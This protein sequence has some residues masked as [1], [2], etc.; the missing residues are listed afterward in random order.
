MNSFNKYL[1]SISYVPGIVI[2]P[3]DV[4]VNTNNKKD[5]NPFF[6]ELIW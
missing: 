3:R 2:D 6:G 4:S 5:K 1:L